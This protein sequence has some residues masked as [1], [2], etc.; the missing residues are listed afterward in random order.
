MGNGKT[1][2]MREIRRADP[3]QRPPLGG[4]R[5]AYRL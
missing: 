3:R 5:T 4:F 1:V 2:M